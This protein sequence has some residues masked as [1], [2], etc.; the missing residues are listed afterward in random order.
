MD[1]DQA[2]LVFDEIVETWLR[3]QLSNEGGLLAE[4]VL[5][6]PDQTVAL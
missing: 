4:M 3:E 1:R 2:D 6:D 5:H